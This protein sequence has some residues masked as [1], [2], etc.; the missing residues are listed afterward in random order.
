MA[1]EEVT[2]YGAGM[3]GLIAAVDLARKGYA[4]TVHDREGGLGGSRRF[5]PS[6]HVTPLDVGRTSEYLGIDLAGAFQQVIACPAYFEEVKVMFPVRSV[7]AV[8]RGDRPTSL[9]ALLYGMCADLGVEFV[10]G[11]RLDEESLKRLPARTIIS[12]GLDPRTYDLLG[13]PYLKWEAWLARGSADMGAFAWLWWDREI[14]E[15][16]YFTTANGIY[17]DMLFSIGRGVSRECLRRY[18]RFMV[19]R[20]GVEHHDWDYVTGATPIARPDNPRLF[21]REAVLAGTMTGSIDPM[22]GF[23]IS[24]ALV[25]GK[26]AAMAVY[27]RVRAEEDFRRFNRLFRYSHYFKHRVWWRHIRPRVG[28]MKRAIRL[29]GPENVERV[30]NWVADGRI[31]VVSAIPGFS[32]MSCH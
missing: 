10:W 4:V 6:L 13:I 24:G 5:N 29:A 30:G 14:N 23:G 16:G 25:T 15:Y 2:I 8:E 28:L 22:M 26:V 7:Y 3:S 19:E 12:C 18:E 20:E 1:S 31:P 17:F 9:D 32:Y 27:D 11:S 21:W